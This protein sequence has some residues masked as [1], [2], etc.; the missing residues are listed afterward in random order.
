MKKIILVAAI[1]S[2]TA[3]S[4]A[5]AATIYEGKGLTYELK[6]DLQV[7]LRQKIGED[8][9][10]D[11]EFD[12]LELKNRVTYKLNEGLSAFGQLDFSFDRAANG[13]EDGAKLE[14]AYLGLDFGNVAVRVGKQNYSTDEFSVEKA[15]ETVVND[16]IFDLT[17]DAGDDVIR[18]DAQ[19]DNIFVSVSTDL[20]ADGNSNSDG[21][22]STDLFVSTSV[23]KV[24]LAAAFQS[25]QA[26]GSDSV[27]VWAVSAVYD[28][29]FATF[30]A[31]YG[32]M[33][34]TANVYNLV[35]A[36]PVTNTTKAAIGLQNIDNE[37]ESVDD[38]TG[39]YANVTYKF[40]EQKNV[41][42]FA[43]IGDTDEDSSS[44]GYLAGLQIKF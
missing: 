25:Y 29:G 43:E 42:L 2:I 20:E 33:E 38:V 7:Q 10:T 37:D 24:D 41:S 17:G 5:Q 23:G 8:K 1:S 32:S 34:D 6:G 26:N 19:F 21:D 12:D 3:F 11:I 18:V 27:N 30:G 4:S 9:N 35:A 39:W 28:A 16:D 13:G 36:F 31:D 15:Y 44:M 14:E 22:Q 40:P